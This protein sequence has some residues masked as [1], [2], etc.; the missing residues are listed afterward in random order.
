MYIAVIFK[1]KT[2]E[3]GTFSQPLLE[4]FIIGYSKQNML[5]ILQFQNTLHP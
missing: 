5:Q 1:N 4:L 2:T 3:L